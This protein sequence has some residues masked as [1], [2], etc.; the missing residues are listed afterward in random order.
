MLADFD[1]YFRYLRQFVISW[2]NKKIGLIQMETQKYP[3]LGSYFHL[4]HFNLLSSRINLLKVKY[5]TFL[6]SNISSD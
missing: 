1:D 3:A 4:H 6:A 2:G 5:H